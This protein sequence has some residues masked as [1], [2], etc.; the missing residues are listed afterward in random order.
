MR[1]LR[2]ALPLGAFAS[3]AAIAAGSAV[4]GGDAGPPLYPSF[5][6][7]Q[8]VQTETLIAKA[9]T[10]QDEG[11]TAK[12][13]VALNAA[14]SHMH[15]AWLAAKFYID[16]APP[17]VAGDSAAFIVPK[18]K[19][20]TKTKPQSKV[21][22]KAKAHS[23]GGAVAGASPYADQYA[24]AVAVLTLEHDVAAAALGIMESADATLLP[25]VNTTLFNALND[26]D[27]AIAYIHSV[28]VPPAASDGSVKG[29]SS[30]GAVA[31]SWGTVMPGVLPYVDDELS[32]VDSLRARLKLSPGRKRMLDD[33]E[34]QDT[35]TERTINKYWPPLPADG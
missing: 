30:G 16:N 6:N 27:T 19:Q 5:V 20:V 2:I 28:D 4:A 35:K 23:S 17:P 29:H 31:G 26:R 14:R 15:K 8:M 24:T 18:A 22:K 34:L 13:V 33:T 12:A 21:K 32:T 10:Y 9:A 25:V 7:V 11:D 3:F 1:L